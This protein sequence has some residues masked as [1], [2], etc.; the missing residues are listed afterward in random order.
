MRMKMR[1]RKRRSLISTSEYHHIHL[2]TAESKIINLLSSSPR[3]PLSLSISSSTTG[4][5]SHL[6]SPSSS[7]AQI[8]GQH[9][10]APRHLS[11][12]QSHLNPLSHKSGLESPDRFAPGSTQPHPT[13]IS[14]RHIIDA[15][16]RQDFGGRGTHHPHRAGGGKLTPAKPNDGEEGQ[17][18]DIHDLESLRVRSGSRI[19][20]AAE[21]RA[22][23]DQQIRA[24][25]DTERSTTPPPSRLGVGVGGEGVAKTP[26]PTQKKSGGG[27]GERKNGGEGQ[28][29][30]GSGGPHRAFACELSLSLSI[31]LRCA[32]RVLILNGFSLSR[33]IQ[34]FGQ[35]ESDTDA[36]D[37]SDD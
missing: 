21:R 4:A 6:V 7:S 30:S 17:W 10:L 32:W 11:A 20:S 36:G 34:V 8:Q 26:R 29:E 23:T 27:R 16:A 22:S 35:D 12:F 33:F 13:P 24:G 14:T 3:L 28:E 1:K 5:S 9:Q 37:D 25:E 31:S 19:P 2:L 15:L 18:D